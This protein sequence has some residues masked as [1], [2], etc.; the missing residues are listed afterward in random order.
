LNDAFKYRFRL[1][2]ILIISTEIGLLAALHCSLISRAVLEQAALNRAAGI[3][4]WPG[5]KRRDFTRAA[6]RDRALADVN[7]MA[8]GLPFH[9]NR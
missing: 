6:V 8:R 5:V 7:M 9:D 4:S 2:E 3:S 1:L